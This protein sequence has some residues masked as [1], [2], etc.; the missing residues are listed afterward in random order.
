MSSRRFRCPVCGEPQT[1]RRPMFRIDHDPDVWVHVD[2]ASP[3][4][5]EAQLRRVFGIGPMAPH[6][7]VTSESYQGGPTRVKAG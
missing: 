5:W 2:C 6:E 1:R 4:A 3:E 7:Q